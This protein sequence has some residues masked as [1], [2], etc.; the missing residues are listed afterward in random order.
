[1][2]RTFAVITLLLSLVM[3]TSAQS[4]G[5]KIGTEYYPD[6]GSFES[7]KVEAVFAYSLTQK[8]DVSLTT[9]Y[10]RHHLDQYVEYHPIGVVY[11]QSATLVARDVSAYTFHEIPI[12]AGVK[13]SFLQTVVAPYLSV[14]GGVF[15]DV[16]NDN[17]REARFGNIRSEKF[18]NGLLFKI[19]GGIKYS[20]EHNMFL[21]CSAKA[22]HPSDNAESIEVMAGVGIQL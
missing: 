9:G 8:I 13:Y 6:N 17:E 12:I 3:L 4:I 2:M 20:F 16:G 14:E 21:D 22:I 5:V 10:Y 1:M 15:Y 18:A 19:G 11:N 7:Q